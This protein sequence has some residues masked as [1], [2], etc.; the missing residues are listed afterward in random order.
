MKVHILI[1]IDINTRL[2]NLF[3]N[4]AC[5]CVKG[6]TNKLSFRRLFSCATRPKYVHKNADDS[7]ATPTMTEHLRRQTIIL[8]DY[9]VDAGRK[10]VN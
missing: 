6:K 1:P 10:E 4:L 8:T 3:G 2:V 9:S 7:F 5:A